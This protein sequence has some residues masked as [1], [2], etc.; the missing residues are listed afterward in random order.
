MGK[1]FLLDCTLRDGGYI[2]DWKFG[3]KAIKDI[4]RKL[5][6]T[7]VEMIEVGFLKGN[8]YV[9]DKSLFPNTDICESVIETKNPDVTY[10]GML[11]M[12][13]PLPMD[14]IM[15][16]KK[17]SID[18]IRIIFKK[19]KINEAYEY[20]E[21]I[22]K[23]GYKLF[24]NFV[25]TDQYTDKEFIEAI[26]KF[27]PLNPTGM[28]IVDTFGAIKRKHFMRL[29][30]IADHNMNDGI[31]LCYHAHNNLQQAAGNA[32]AMLE[33]NMRRDLVIDACVFGMGRGAGNLN[34]EL[35]AGFMND[36]YGT[37]YRIEPMLE[38]MDDYLSYFYK[39]KQWGYSLPL[40]LSATL[41]C[42]PNYAI[43]LGE[44]DTLTE[45]SF[46]EL[47]KNIPA[48]D[49]FN[50]SKEAAEKYY[51]QYME[52]FIDDRQ[53]LE[54][55]SEALAGKPVVI[56]APGSS[57][58]DNSEKIKGA[59]EET[60]ANTIAVNFVAE[61]FTPDFVFSSNMR[62]YNKIQGNTKAKT[63]ITSNMRDYDAAD[64]IV[65]F[66]SYASESAEIVDNSGLM[67]IKMLI[68]IGIKD[69]Y[70]A[71]FDGYYPDNPNNYAYSA[72]EY[73]FAD[74]E[75]RNKLICNEIKKLRNKVNIIF[76]TESLYNQGGER[77]K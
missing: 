27:N 29:C 72:I 61:E 31:M 16:R 34:L 25:G 1:V 21:H 69:I 26:E 23:Q 18:G 10:V 12:S 47:L 70:L 64:Y 2:N 50:F 52:N 44:K 33:M 7:G 41:G 3:N 67:L 63:I 60:D 66:S 45:K 35:F 65:N 51:L 24:V 17:S 62:R 40:Y 56:L 42:H 43:Y 54:T 13:A 74:I 8:N 32:E 76:I 49:K 38:I 75:K 6:Y 73:K 14:C 71:G 22:Q 59:I 77:Q 5:S 30:A 15:P 53:T 9:P 36:S 46:N 19:N 20:C 4:I 11:D 58:K 28:T 57:L 37:D 68:A 39:E 55:L 48:P